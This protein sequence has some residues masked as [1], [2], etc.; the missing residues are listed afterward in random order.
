MWKIQE[1]TFP[2]VPQNTLMYKTEY[3]ITQRLK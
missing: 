2:I 3:K 1:Q